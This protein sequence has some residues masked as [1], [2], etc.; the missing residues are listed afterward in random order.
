MNQERQCDITISWKNKTHLVVEADIYDPEDKENGL[1]VQPKYTFEAE[2][3]NPKHDFAA[4]AGAVKN[5][6]RVAYQLSFAY[7]TSY[8]VYADY[9]V[10]VK[11]RGHMR[12]LAELADWTESWIKDNAKELEDEEI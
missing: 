10:A 6:A 9:K 8:K 3:G 1:H 12:W 2:V 11:W 5:I 4:M 7:P